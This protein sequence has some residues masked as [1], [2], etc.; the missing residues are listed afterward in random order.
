MQFLGS[1]GRGSMCPGP[2][3]SGFRP[4][5]NSMA[6]PPLGDQ[7]GPPSGACSGMLFRSGLY[8]GKHPNGLSL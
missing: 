4:R 8:P 6:S 1:G 5:F 3:M 2:G 7:H